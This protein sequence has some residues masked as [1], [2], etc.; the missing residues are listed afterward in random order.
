M[1][2]PYSPV[3]DRIGGTVLLCGSAAS[4][5]DDLNAAEAM[6]PGA[7]VW[8]VNTAFGAV[9]RGVNL[10]THHHDR[11]AWLRGLYR[12]L[13]GTNP[14]VHTRRPEGE[15]PHDRHNRVSVDYWWS[16]PAFV[17]GSS[18]MWAAH[19]CAQVFDEVILCGI[20]LSPGGYHPDVVLDRQV[21][22]GE[23]GWDD[24]RGAVTR[25]QGFAAQYAREG[26]LPGVRSMSG[27]TRDVF[28]APV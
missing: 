1:T 13:R 28:G 26:S 24:S 16:V 18:G 4:V 9:E 14:V 19:V 15:L 22:R 25:Y 23:Y 7:P 3:F 6:R 11:S 21:R 8:C 10:L 12:Y 17:G 5:I 20:P 27:Y 2:L